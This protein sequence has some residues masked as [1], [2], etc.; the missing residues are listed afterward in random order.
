MY[1]TLK[2]E[3]G[4]LRLR[5]NVCDVNLGG[6]LLNLGARTLN[7]IKFSNTLSVSNM[8]GR[9]FRLVY[10]LFFYSLPA[11]KNE[12]LVSKILWI[13]LFNLCN[14]VCSFVQVGIIVQYLK[15][16][17]FLCVCVVKILSDK[18]D[19][20]ETWTASRKWLKEQKLYSADMCFCH[21]SGCNRGWK[22]K[23]YVLSKQNYQEQKWSL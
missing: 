8:K 2:L 13:S 5:Y 22:S 20:R 15:F 6:E 3:F 4:N 16:L 14:F 19:W 23:P 11:A 17:L 7:L 12:L 10:L 1:C 18:T 9:K 21:G